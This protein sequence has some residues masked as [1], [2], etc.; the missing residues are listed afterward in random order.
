MPAI[1]LDGNK[2]LHDMCR[3][4]P[5]GS[6]SYD[7]AEAAVK[8]WMQRGLFMGSKVTLSPQNI[9]YLYEAF[10]NMVNLNYTEIMANVVYEKGWEAEHATIMY[11][12]QK[13]IAD[14][15]LDNNYSL[16]TLFN[17]IDTFLSNLCDN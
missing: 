13:K 16:D 1:T 7:L 15:I 6:P 8:D 9:S 4:V 14:Y 12:Q 3:K 10:I 5:D 17:Q 11:E 2:E